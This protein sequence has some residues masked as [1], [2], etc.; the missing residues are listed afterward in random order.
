MWYLEEEICDFS[1]YDVPFLQHL[2]LF[3]LTCVCQQEASNNSG[4]NSSSSI[5]SST[6]GNLITS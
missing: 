5:S 3:S 2:A 6:M 1:F 4:S